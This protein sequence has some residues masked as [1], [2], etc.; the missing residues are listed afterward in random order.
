MATLYQKAMG[1]FIGHIR[2][3]VVFYVVAAS[4]Q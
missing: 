2:S 1:K 4:L 3:D